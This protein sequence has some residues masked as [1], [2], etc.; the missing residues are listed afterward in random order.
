MTDAEKVNILVVDDLPEKLLV[1][2]SILEE[3]GQNIVTARSG[4]DALKQLLRHNYAVILLDVN[5]PGMDGLETAALIRKHKRF[6]HTPLIFITA[7][8]DD[9]RPLQGYAYGAVDFMLAPVVP[10]VL[11]AKVKVFVDLFR[12]T[13]EVRRRA[14][15]RVVLAEEQLRRVAAEEANRRSAFLAE[16]S[17]ILATSLDLEATL[18]GLARLAVPALADMSMACLADQNGQLHHTV[19][20][21]AHL[22]EGT[23]SRLMPEVLHLPARFANTMERVLATGRLEL[24]DNLDQPAPKSPGAAS[25]TANGWPTTIPEFN[26]NAALVLPLQARGKTFGLLALTF[27]PSGRR[28]LPGDL[29]LAEDVASRAGIAVDNALLLRSIQESDQR[30]DEF[31]AMLAHELRNPLASI[32]NAV[33]VIRLLGPQEPQLQ[34]S[35]DVIDRQVVQLIRLVDDLL[36]VSRITRGKIQLRPERIE[37]G[38]VVGNAIE[39]SRPLIDS[40]GQELNVNLPGEPVEVEGDPARLA[41]ILSNLLNNAAKYTQEKGRIWLSA[42]QEG[43]EA[44]FRVRDD[45]PGI[46]PEMLPRIFDLFAQGHQA[47]YRRREGRNPRAEEHHQHDGGP[48]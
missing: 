38:V 24:V 2:E 20:A 10:E 12:M 39:T 31:L 16:A 37:V 1:Y 36:D 35:R 25:L 11:R 40:R 33:Q 30:K 34:Q 6:A 48:A 21:W 22:S 17:G 28:F 47:D 42:A 45:G 7:F 8:L 18:R 29:S 44:V 19:W 4:A 13:Q 9:V 14:E 15:E 26:L 27:G 3:L 23:S 43:N 5:M 46:S 41:Q 32:R